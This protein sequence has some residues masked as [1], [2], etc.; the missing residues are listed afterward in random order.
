MECFLLFAQ[1]RRTVCNRMKEDLALHLIVHVCIWNRCIYIWPQRETKV[2][3]ISLV[4]RWFDGSLNSYSTLHT[5]SALAPTSSLMLDHI[6]RRLGPESNLGKQFESSCAV[7]TL[8]HFRRHS[9]LHAGGAGGL[10]VKS[11]GGFYS[12]CGVAETTTRGAQLTDGRGVN[13]RGDERGSDRSHLCPHCNS[14][15]LEDYVWWVSGRK[16]TKWWCA[17][18]GKSTIGSNRTGFL[19]VQTGDSIE[20]AKVFKAHALRQGLCTNLINALKLL[21]N[22]Q[23]ES[24]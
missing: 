21:A 17:L 18:C 7:D 23:E 13:E 10:L 9:I 3:F 24:G 6:R 16:S 19:V 1:H 15:P 8:M 20:Q 2:V 22:Q 12:R 4:Q 14:F 11:G 5:F